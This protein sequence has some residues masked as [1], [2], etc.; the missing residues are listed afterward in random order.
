LLQSAR[1]AGF[2]R[3][4]RAESAHDADLIDAILASHTAT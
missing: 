3:V 4:L 1:A 2:A